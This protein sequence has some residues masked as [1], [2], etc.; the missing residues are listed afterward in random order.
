MPKFQEGTVVSDR[1]Q[2]TAVVAAESLER[3]PVYKKL[4]RRTRRFKADNELGA[5]VGDRVRLVE[6][7]PISKE[8]RWRIIEVIS[9]K[10]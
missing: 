10:S 4:I 5:Q 2:K 8:K 9:K 1:M 7:R 3:H 6:S